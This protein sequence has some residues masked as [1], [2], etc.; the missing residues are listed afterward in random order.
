MTVLTTQS[1]CRD[2]FQ[3]RIFFLDGFIE[4]IVTLF[5]DRTPVFVADLDIF[6]RERCRMPVFDALAA[7]FGRA[8]AQRI[9]DGIEYILDEGIDL[10]FLA[11]VAYTALTAQTD[12][13][14]EH[15][16][17]TDILA[18]LQKFMIA[19]A[20]RGTIPPSVV[21]TRTGHRIANGFLP[22]DAI[23]KGNTLDYTTARPTDEC[24]PHGFERFGDIFTQ[25]VCA[26]TKRFE[27]EQRN[28]IQQQR[29]F[30]FK[31]DNE[32]SAGITARG[33]QVSGV[34]APCFGHVDGQWT[35]TEFLTIFSDEPD[36]SFTVEAFT[37]RG[38]QTQVIPR[39]SCPRIRCCRS[40]PVPQREA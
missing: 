27:G 29:A 25:S 8:V 18:E 24:R 26:V 22:F 23:R 33:S 37:V 6:Q 1:E 34:F 2:E 9:V 30:T 31:F 20:H 12:I 19:E 11:S 17:G 16:P 21:N 7:P 4:F 5:I 10:I 28:I 14:D 35:V 36:D 40:P 15:A 32:M 39:Y 13:A 3:L 38:V